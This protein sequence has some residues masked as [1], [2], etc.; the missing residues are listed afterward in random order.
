MLTTRRWPCP[1]FR[2]IFVADRANNC[3]KLL[4]A[5]GLR[6]FAPDCFTATI[7]AE[8]Y[9]IC[10]LGSGRRTLTF[11]GKTRK[12]NARSCN[13]VFFVGGGPGLADSWRDVFRPPRTTYFNRRLQIK[14]PMITRFLFFG[15][16]A[17]STSSFYWQKRET[18]SKQFQLSLKM[19]QSQMRK[20]S[21]HDLVL[22]R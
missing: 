11:G 10:L 4:I 17:F 20:Y 5:N 3:R 8:L 1:I 12:R 18:M 22:S 19:P 21:C 14:L 9:A 13:R 6:V 2:V 16:N 7:P 15:P